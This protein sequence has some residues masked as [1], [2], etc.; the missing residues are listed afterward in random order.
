MTQIVSV[1]DF[2]VTFFYTVND[3]VK[4]LEGHFN[5]SNYIQLLTNAHF[6]PFFFTVNKKNT[7]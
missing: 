4:K 6:R 3:T 5:Y 2:K 1:T 7:P